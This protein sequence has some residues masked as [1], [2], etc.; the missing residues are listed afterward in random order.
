MKKVN[1]K[2]GPMSKTEDSAIKPQT[3]PGKSG[4][5]HMNCGERISDVRYRAFIEEIRDGVYETDTYGN[6][7]YFNNSLCI[8]FGY[9]REEIQGQN[10]SKFMDEK[11]A[12]KAYEAFTKIW[13]THKGFSD[14]V[15]EIVDKEGK[16]RIIELSAQLIKDHKGKKTGF[17]G[18]ARD[19]TQ[20]INTITALRESELRYQRE[21][22]ASRRA[23]K[24]ARSLLDFVL[25]PM[26][27]FSLEGEVAYL[28]PA[29]TKVFGWTLDELR[30]KRIPYVPEGLQRETEENI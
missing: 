30:G 13:V 28:N 2:K 15:W 7:T 10:F 17:R 16:T 14:L 26:F 25:Y 18:I 27:V 29:F 23:V 12:R 1:N 8:V 11:H 19:V 4:D 9:P 5:D 24:W 22:E 20:K 3:A 21:Y 6:F